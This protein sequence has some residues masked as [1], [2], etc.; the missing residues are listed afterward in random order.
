ME[1]L[2][3]GCTVLDTGAIQSPDSIN[4]EKVHD[5]ITQM[6]KVSMTFKGTRITRIHSNNNCLS[7]INTVLDRE[8]LSAN[9][10]PSPM[11]TVGNA[12]HSV[13]SASTT[14]TSAFE[15]W[16]GKCEVCT[17]VNNRNALST[18]TRSRASS[19][20]SETRSVSPHSSVSNRGRGK[21]TVI[22]VRTR[23]LRT[24]YQHTLFQP[25]RYVP[26]PTQNTKRA[27]NARN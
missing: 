21:E 27:P 25:K 5:L 10:P 19:A 8:A 17:A 1:Q 22:E 16:N 6:E 24:L 7:A 2:V 3:S 20:N 4:E 12:G 15:R 26:T 14:R 9:N 13:N 11:K 23:C 18:N